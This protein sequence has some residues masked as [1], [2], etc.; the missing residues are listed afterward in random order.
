MLQFS[1]A[2]DQDTLTYILFISIFTF[3]T[4]FILPS[5]KSSVFV[6]GIEIFLQQINILSID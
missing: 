6:Y 5:N 1:L 2:G 4:N 3:K